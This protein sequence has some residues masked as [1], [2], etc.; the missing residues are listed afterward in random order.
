M[1]KGFCTLSLA[2]TT[3]RSRKRKE[4][5]KEIKIHASLSP[6]PQSLVQEAEGIIAILK[7]EKEKG[8]RRNR[9]RKR[10][11][12]VEAEEEDPGV[13]RIIST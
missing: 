12:V 11:E 5:K 7:N 2:T 13:R 3:I 4:E 8:W 6:P 10:P 9:R 1:K